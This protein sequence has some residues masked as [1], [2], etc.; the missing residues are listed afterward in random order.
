MHKLCRNSRSVSAHMP[1]SFLGCRP[2]GI[3]SLVVKFEAADTP[4]VGSQTT[5]S[6]VKYEAANTPF[7]GSQTA[8]SVVKCEAAN[9]VSDDASAMEKHWD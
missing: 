1:L 6:V 7:V 9:G 2:E 5:V 3:A 4:F 8:V